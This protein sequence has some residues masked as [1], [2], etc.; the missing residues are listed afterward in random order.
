M[1][2]LQLSIVL[3]ICVTMPVIR[4]SNLSFAQ[5]D[6]GGARTYGVPYI[7]DSPLKQFKSGIKAG[8]VKCTIR[9]DLVLNSEDHGPTRI[10]SADVSHFMESQVWGK[11]HV[12][13]ATFDVRQ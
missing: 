5:I 12:A 9:F 10:K 11:M 2:T 4:N 13:I 7:L 6:L 3:G 8:N 1:K